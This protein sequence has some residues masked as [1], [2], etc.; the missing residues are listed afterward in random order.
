[1][2]KFLTKRNIIILIVV[3]LITGLWIK[4]RNDSQAKTKKTTRVVEVT[5]GEVVAS[6]T[7][8]GEILAE[9]QAVLH[10]PASG[11]LG[12][13]GVKTGDMV[14]KWQTLAALDLGDLQTVQ[15]RAFYQYQAADAY[16]KL[17]EDAVKDHDS[18]E[19]FTQKNS[20][21]AAQTARDIAYD[22]WLAAQRAV[23]N[24]RLTAPFAGVIT[25][26]T[27]NAIGDTVSVTDGVTL[28]DPQSLYF[29]A[30]VDESDIGKIS[31]DQPVM[32]TLD[33]F[34]AEKFPG[35][36]TDVGY[37]SHVSSTGATVFS[38]KVMLTGEKLP[39]LRMGMNGDAEIILATKNNVLTLPFDA[40]I[41]GSVIMSGKEENKVKI[42]VGLEGVNTVEIK[43]GLNEG[44][45]VV[46]K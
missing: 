7:V 21:V 30:D 2:R 6:I 10:F 25:N 13:I 5:K 8:S 17:I 46:I 37:V 45:K 3:V 15:S 43:A 44:D 31:M 4:N 38:V 18:D 35:K 12:Y 40:V 20:R 39:T 11:K 16:A 14:K 9:K 19:T 42:D 29:S 36:I 32:I 23:N 41:D 24:A 26:I 27:A 1:M 33:A 34:G 22:S 28:I